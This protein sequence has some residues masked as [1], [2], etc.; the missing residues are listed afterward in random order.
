MS[1]REQ[2]SLAI[3]TMIAPLR[4]RIYTMITRA[5]IETVNDTGEMQLVKVN[6]LAGETRSDVERFQNF[7]FTSVPPN[8]AE[9]VAIAV[10]GNRDHLIVI[11]ADDRASRIVGLLKGES[12][13]YNA[14]GDKIHLKADGTLEATFLKL[15]LSNG[16]D[17]LIDLLVQTLTALNV[18]PFIIN[19]ATFALIKTKLEA[20]KV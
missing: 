6:L 15:S 19:K 7:G 14:N 10:G 17:E 18:E 1:M 5:V 3:A 13:Q 4:N 9:C 11:A 8:G 12:V 20:F 16:S 2:I